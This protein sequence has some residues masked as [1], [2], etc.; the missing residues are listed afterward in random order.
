MKKRSV[1][2]ISKGQALYDP[3]KGL[4]PYDPHFV[5]ALGVSPLD[6]ALRLCP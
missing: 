3:L 2:S 5:G 4:A 1:A 6:F